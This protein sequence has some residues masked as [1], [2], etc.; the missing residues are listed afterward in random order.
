MKASALTIFICCVL[1]W[2]P[3]IFQLPTKCGNLGKK[4]LCLGNKPRMRTI[5]N[6]LAVVQPGSWRTDKQG[7]PARGSNSGI[8]E[9]A[10]G[11]SQ[12]RVRL[13]MTAAH[14]WKRC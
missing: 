11:N 8:C 10:R 5:S 3:K 7:D 4:F 6:R 1:A 2:N 12:C 14:Q 13:V 9:T